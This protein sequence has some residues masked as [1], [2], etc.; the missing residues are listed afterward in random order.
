MSLRD[1]GTMLAQGSSDVATTT[2]TLNLIS[3]KISSTG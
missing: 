3:V 1:E 2:V